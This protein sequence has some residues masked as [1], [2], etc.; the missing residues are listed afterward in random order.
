MIELTNKY[1]YNQCIRLAAQL[2]QISSA[3][4]GCAENTCDDYLDDD[5]YNALIEISY[6]I[7]KIASDV[8]QSASTYI[9][10]RG[11]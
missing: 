3:L 9:V 2:D 8:S 5:T 7:A 11:E 6:D 4:E 10:K 1:D